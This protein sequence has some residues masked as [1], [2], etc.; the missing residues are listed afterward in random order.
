M[1]VFMYKSITTGFLAH[2]AEENTAPLEL[3]KACLIK[4][5]RVFILS[6][7]TFLLELPPAL[8]LSSK[9]NIAF[10]AIDSI[11]LCLALLIGVLKP[12]SSGFES[13]FNW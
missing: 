12:C 6:A 7:F 4:V 8:W 10:G 3:F 13:L 5:A 11:K 2:V 9:I 1:S